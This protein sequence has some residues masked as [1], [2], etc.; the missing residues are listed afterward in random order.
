MAIADAIDAVAEK[1]LIRIC[2]RFAGLHPEC[3]A[4]SSDRD[5]MSPSEQRKFQ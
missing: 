1:P 2:D 5:A 4:V 3:V